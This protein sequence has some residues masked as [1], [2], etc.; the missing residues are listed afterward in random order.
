MTARGIRALDGSSRLFVPDPN[1][2]DPVVARRPDGTCIFFNRDGRRLCIIHG[3]AGLDALPSA[4]RHFPRE[5]LEDP[6]GSFISLS[7]YCPTAAALLLDADPSDALT[8]VR[9]APPLRIDGPIEGM[10]AVTALPPLLRPGVLSDLEGYD[11]WERG[12]LA[13]LA[14]P[15]LTY[16]R[17]LGIIA[18]ATDEIRKWSPG[19]ES[20]AT[21]VARTLGEGG[22]HAT[23]SFQVEAARALDR[24]QPEEAPLAANAPWFRL[25]AAREF[26]STAAP[27][28]EFD[29]VWR[30]CVEP[31]LGAMDPAIRNFLAARL[32]GNW[33]AY[34]GVGWRTVVAWVCTA[35]GVLENE[36][37]R[38]CLASGAPLTRDDFIAAVGT[39]DLLLLHTID[40]ERLAQH[41]APAE[42]PEPA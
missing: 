38:R 29:D 21:R 17:A 23:A 20:L 22:A 24:V 40:S 30:T 26:P 8:I 37:A 28:P 10:D 31:S 11:A 41:F 42:G 7:H 35:A 19:E 2:R 13:T 12:C 27:L 14:R 36:L 1:G 6:R 4:C 25:L 34:Q 3:V 33:V 16:R 9:A 18:A 32:F 15:D 5:I 39:T